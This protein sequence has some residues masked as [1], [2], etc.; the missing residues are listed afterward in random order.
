M[1]ILESKKDVDSR[2]KEP[3]QNLSDHER[4]IISEQLIVPEVKV[5]YRAL[6]RYATTRDI[7]ILSSCSV[8]A[9]AAGAV[10]PLMTVCEDAPLLVSLQHWL[11]QYRL[12]LVILLACSRNFFQER[13]QRRPSLMSFIDLLYTMCILV[14]F[15]FSF[16]AL[17][18]SWNDKSV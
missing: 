5:T 11:T 6:Y 1:E 9:I 16:Q 4:G 17:H 15:T 3:F 13:C 12:S 2:E 7:L 8:C 10:L 14:R 18:D